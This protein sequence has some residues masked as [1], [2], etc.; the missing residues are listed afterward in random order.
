MKYNTLESLRGLAA[1]VVALYHS[2]FV[3]DGRYPVIGQGSIFVDFFFVLSGFVMAFAYTEKISQGYRFSDFVLLR[4]G[5]L[6]PLHIFML[7]VWLP[8][9][10]A[11]AYAHH[12]LGM[13]TDPFEKNSLY[14][15]VSNILLLNS[16][17][18]HA[19]E[20]WNTPSWSISVEFYTYLVF[21]FSVFALRI[22]RAVFAPLLISVAA[23]FVLYTQNSFSLLATTDWGFFRCIGGF[24]L[25][26]TI[27]QATHARSLNLPVYAISALEIILLT[28]TLFAVTFSFGNRLLQ[29]CCFLLFAIL[30]CIFSLQE[31]GILSRILNLGLFQLFGKLSYSIYMTHLIVFLVAGNVWEFVL[32]LPVGG[33]ETAKMFVTPYA[34]LINV[35]LLAFV[36]CI[37][38]LTYRYIEVPFRDKFR[39]I[40]HKRK[41]AR[42]PK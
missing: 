14:S 18:L 19:T 34:N 3:V 25:G 27:Y 4:F 30:I 33:T 6:Y 41:I 17:G 9:I 12:E 24:F 36:I 20:S 38:Y 2:G 10:L 16:M 28:I 26:V 29:I 11:K 1:I 35:G 7:L 39:T 8:Y 15:F 23:Y 32:K 31:K 42:T 21:Y 13:G 5:R 40:V 37:S 22:Q